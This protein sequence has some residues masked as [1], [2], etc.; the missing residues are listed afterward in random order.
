LFIWEATL[1]AN[2]LAHAV[3]EIAASK[4]ADNILM[5]DMREVTL[6]ADYYILCDGTS[7]RQIDA[8]TGELMEKLKKEGTRPASAE[9]TPESGWV[10]VDFGSVIAHIF[11]PEQRTYYQ[12]E[13]LWQDAPIVVRML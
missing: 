8:I 12:L 1:E 11:S 9:G 3:V 10:L 5:L 13:E 4:K 2:E 6:L 7:S